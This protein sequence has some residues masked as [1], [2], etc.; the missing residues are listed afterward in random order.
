MT[1]PPQ[2]LGKYQILSELGRGGF[3]TVFRAI[4]NTLDREVALKVLDP[5]LLRDP[6]W[7]SRFRREARAVA[8]L[9][10]PHI[11]T[12]FEVGEAEGRLFLA[13]QL[14]EGGGL[15]SLLQ[16]RGVLPWAEV[17]Q[18]LSQIADALDYAHKQGV[19]HRDLKPSN[20]LLGERGAMLSD[21]GFA[22]LVGESSVSVSSSGGVVG[23]PNYIAPEVWEGQPAVPQTD[24]YA[25]GCILYEMVTGQQLFQGDSVAAVMRA[26]FKPLQLPQTWPEGVPPGLADVLRAALTQDPRSRATCAEDIAGALSDLP[27]VATAPQTAAPVRCAACHTLNNP[28]AAFCEK[29]GRPLRAPHTPTP[30]PTPIPQAEADAT[31]GGPPAPQQGPAPQALVVYCPK[32]SKANEATARFCEK[33]GHPLAAITPT[34]LRG[35]AVSATPTSTRTSSPASAPTPQPSSRPT[36]PPATAPATAAERRRRALAARIADV[37]RL[38]QLEVW[39]RA[40]QVYGEMAAADEKERASWSAEQARCQ[41]EA[42]LAALFDRGAA[43]VRARQWVEANRLL[44]ELVRRRPRYARHGQLVSELMTRVAVAIHRGQGG[45]LPYRG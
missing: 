29:C 24:L 44:S 31:R 20:I 12:I 7:T 1:E 43:A 9:S 17:Q 3:A 10:H 14:V 23:T 40:A 26:H 36:S 37:R 32:C 22:R 30:M 41:E 38:E 19:L 16:R 35:Q 4:D 11:V 39:D 6:A 45:K 42:E 21:F 25:L 13:M 28:G 8:R 27:P 34:P 18:H 2:Q 15:D 33:C 5:L